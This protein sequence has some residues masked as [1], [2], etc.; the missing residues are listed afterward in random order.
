MHVKY[1]FEYT[2]NIYITAQNILLNY[3]NM[4]LNYI[5]YFLNVMKIVLKHVNISAECPVHFFNGTI[6]LLSKKIT[7][8]K[9]FKNYKKNF[10]LKG[11][12]K[13]TVYISFML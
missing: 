5:K 13:I 3:A 6:F 10:V 11:V 4:F 1:F 8:Y 2:L 7:L 9:K 12:K